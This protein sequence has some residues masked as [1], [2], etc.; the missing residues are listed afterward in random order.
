MLI[1][2]RAKGYIAGDRAYMITQILLWVSKG[3]GH[4]HN[5]MVVHVIISPKK[6]EKSARYFHLAD[7]LF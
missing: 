1:V 4:P 5:N 2:L 7:F 3:D 6:I